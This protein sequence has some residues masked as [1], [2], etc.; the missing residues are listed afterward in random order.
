MTAENVEPSPDGGKGLKSGAAEGYRGELRT[1]EEAPPVGFEPTTRR[2]TAGCSTD[3]TPGI[4]GVPA[5]PTADM[6]DCIPEL[7]R[8]RLERLLAG[9][10]GVPHEI[11]VK[12][13]ALLDGAS[14]RG[15]PEG[16]AEPDAPRAEGEQPSDE[17]T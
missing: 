14:N 2:L 12:L 10:E 11:K 4:P 17:P 7:S 8:S 13:L 3:E 6:S 9:W 5:G 15:P 1:A 16:T